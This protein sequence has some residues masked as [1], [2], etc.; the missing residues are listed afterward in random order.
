MTFDWVTFA[1]QLVNVL[2]LLAILR[3]F[4]FRPVAAVIARRQAETEATLK[5]ATDA[6][7]AADAA[8]A[9]ARA[10][11][12]ATQAA[13]HDLLVK[14]QGEAR[15]ET[16]ALLD[17]AR[18][19]AARIVA[20]GKAQAK[21][22][23]ARAAAETLALARDLAAAVARRALA[24]QPAGLAGYAERLAASL[25]ALTPGERAALLQGDG[26]RIVTPRPL[27]ARDRTAVT[28]ALAPF[29]VKPAETTDPALIAGLELRSANGAIRN[30]LAHD[31]DRIAEAMRDERG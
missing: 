26:L 30:S 15:T 13:R 10:E 16:D 12:D 1:F 6:R 18:D 29:G 23:S 2:V 11:S 9:R 31:L 4:L 27:S 3:H 24:A 21:R 19:E 28:R 8:M 5:A 25:W 7:A 17:K 22:E 20:G 14:A